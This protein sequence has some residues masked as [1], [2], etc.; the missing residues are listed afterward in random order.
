MTPDI[1]V[2]FTS[3]FSREGA[4][5]DSIHRDEVA[6]LAKPVRGMN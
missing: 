1:P 3:G 5:V 6:F 2:I 4:W